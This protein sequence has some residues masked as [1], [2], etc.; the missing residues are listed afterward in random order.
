MFFL[1]LSPFHP[2]ARSSAYVATSLQVVVLTNTP[3]E[4][5]LQVG[6]VCH[7]RGIK[8]VVADTRGLFGQLFCDFGEEMIVRDSTG[9]EPLSAVIS[10]VTKDCP[11]VV[12]C[13]EE[14]QHGFES[15]DFVSFSQVQGMS[16]LNDMRPIEIQVLGIPGLGVVRNGWPEQTESDWWVRL[17]PGA[18][19]CGLSRI[20]GQKR[21]GTAI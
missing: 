15:G 1:L 16:E 7:S 18:H 21:G 11:G 4:Y 8:L 19:F 20:G 12:T 3:L 6:E 17:V 14:A 10:V 9:E 2:S 5:Q 13:L